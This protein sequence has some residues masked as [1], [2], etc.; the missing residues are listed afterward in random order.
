LAVHHQVL[1]LTMAA[2]ILLSG[3]I[4]WFADAFITSAGLVDRRW[5]GF[6]K[7]QG[8]RVSDFRQKKVENGEQK[9]GKWATVSPGHFLIGVISRQCRC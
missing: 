9:S 4:A 1:P 7:I 5:R 3:R 8:E 6:G 2:D